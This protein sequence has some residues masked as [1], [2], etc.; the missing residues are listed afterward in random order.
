[1]DG[2]LMKIIK[3]IGENYIGKVN[4]TRIACR[5][6]IIENGMILLSYDTKHNLYM[7]PGGGLEIGETEEECAIREVT[8]ETGMIINAKKCDF[9]IH[10]YYGDYKYITKYYYGHITCKS[11]PRLTDEELEIGLVAKWVRLDD[12]KREFRK[13]DNYKGIDETAVGMYLRELTALE[14]VGENYEN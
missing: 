14:N 4:E 9:E 5:G 7:I 11:K 1:M 6:I 13:F 8:E 2:L 10:E 12:A 3:I